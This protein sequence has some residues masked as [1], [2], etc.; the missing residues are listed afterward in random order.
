MSR[1]YEHGGNIL[2]LARQRGLSPTELI[3]FSASINPLGLSPVVRNAIVNA[4]DTLVHYPDNDCGELKL[5]LAEFHG[6]KQEHFAIANGSTE[7]IYT[8]PGLL[9]GKSALIVSPTFSEYT[10]ALRLHQREIRH[11]PLSPADGFAL[12]LD[13]LA[14]LLENYYDALYL[15]NP[16]NPSGALYPRRVV[17][18]VYDL[19]RD[20]GTFLVLDEAFMDFSEEESAKTV[21]IAAD[22]GIVLRSMTKFYGIPGLRLGYA[23][24][25]PSLI[26]RLSSLGGPWSV[27]TLAQVAGVAALRDSDY[28]R[29][30]LADVADLRRKL[31]SALSA[32]PGLKVYPSSA[33]FLLIELTA[34]ISSAELK[35][36]LLDRMIL[37]RDCGT[38]TGLT[39]RFIRVAVRTEAE[40]IRLVEGLGSILA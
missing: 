10:N 31:S 35:E 14:S 38:F 5:A 19:C 29:R 7:I 1:P 13:R 37:I 33:N 11:L 22:Q 3:D 20:T 32:I 36:L 23:M 39:N 30:S 21:I 40:N 27:N 6:L 28:I 34:D 18:Q 2:S 25:A 15:C 16:G 4:L 26:E 17:E 12:N 8:L 9:P 24:A